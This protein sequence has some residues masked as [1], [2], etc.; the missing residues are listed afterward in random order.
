MATKR[1]P[2]E[3]SVSGPAVPG[4]G[5]AQPTGGEVYKE[6][7][8]TPPR[9]ASARQGRETPEV[10]SG[11]QQASEEDLRAELARL[12]SVGAEYYQRLTETASKLNRQ[13]AGF[14][15]E[16]RGYVRS[17]P[18]GTFLGAFAVGVIIGVLLGRD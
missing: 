15:D 4:E 1:N 3:R 8:E 16:G 13:V 9:A 2:E 11:T 6:H 10:E 14:Y 12:Q 7:K 18:G 5:A 17:H